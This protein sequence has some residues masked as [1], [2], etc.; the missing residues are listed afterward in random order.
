MCMTGRELMRRLVLTFDIYLLLTII[1]SPPYPL[2]M[3]LRMPQEAPIDGVDA[4]SSNQSP[5]QATPAPA[6]PPL[7]LFPE[8]LSSTTDDDELLQAYSALSSPPSSSAASSSLPSSSLPSTAARISVPVPDNSNSPSTATTEQAP[9]STTDSVATS[10][11]DNQ[12][13][14]LIPSSTRDTDNRAVADDQRQWRGGSRASSRSN[15]GSSSG[16]G[17]V[18]MNTNDVEWVVESRDEISQEESSSLLSR[19]VASKRPSQQRRNKVH[20]NPIDST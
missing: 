14:T 16:E 4:G 13:S 3:S 15:R 19:P 12:P 2:F 5:S 7:S 8:G 10:S 20:P 11:F 9:V 6:I 18:V 17:T 1:S